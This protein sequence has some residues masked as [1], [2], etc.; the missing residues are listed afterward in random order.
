M[1]IFANRSAREAVLLLLVAAIPALLSGWLHPKRPD[2]SWNRPAVEQVNLDEVAR[3]TGPVIWVDARDADS[4][5][6]KH[7]PAA[8]LLN[9][10]S[11]N[12]LVPSFLAAW[13]PGTKVIVYCDTQACDASREVALRLK[14]ELNLPEIYVLKGGWSAWRQANANSRSP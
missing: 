9:E 1:A 2:W 5:A 11:W 14:R 7:V 10:T 13:R 12:S 4:Y 6:E 3:W 8:I